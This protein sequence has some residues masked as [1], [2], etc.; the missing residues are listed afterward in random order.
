M[1]K[2]VT[3]QSSQPVSQSSSQAG[4]QTQTLSSPA[5]AEAKAH[6]TQVKATPS[7][8]WRG[9]LL[10]TLFRLLLLGVGGGITAA[11]GIAV[12]QLYP[13]QSQKLP[14]VTEL[15]QRAEVQLADSLADLPEPLVNLLPGSLV[16]RL[17]PNAQAQ[18][19]NLQADLP[20]AVPNSVQPLAPTVSALT[21]AERQQMQTELT[22]LQAE[23]QTLTSQTAEPLA[24][25]VKEIQK[26]IQAIQV[27][28]NRFTAADPQPFV[29]TPEVSTS[30]DNS[31]GNATGNATDR[32][33]GRQP[34]LVTLP[35][36]ALFESEAVTL[37]P[38]TAAILDSILVDLRRYPGASIQVAAYTDPQQSAE[39]D[40]QKTLEQAR[41]VQKYLAGQM[42]QSI[43][44]VTVGQ[45][46]N[47]P[48]TDDSAVNRQRN[49]RVEISIVP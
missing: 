21:E 1:P 8:S 41:A 30:N 23:L 19:A 10:T 27:N 5:R 39:L 3:P 24:D 31:A 37:R 28:L 2:T 4:L 29:V 48:L 14:L 9:A 40:R 16:Q 15:T 26:R 43:H 11:V 12:A 38:G 45:G 25:R 13:A 22:Q 32:L 44:W 18:Q 33:N 20:E 6:Q 46:H 42:D 34:L 47:R 17:K 35:S 36:D 7:F 49:R